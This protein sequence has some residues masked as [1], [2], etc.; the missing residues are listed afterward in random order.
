LA[1]LDSAPRPD[2]A[3]IHAL[4]DGVSRVI[5]MPVFVTVSSHTQAGEEMIAA[6]NPEKYGAKVCYASPLWDSQ[7]LQQSFV[8]RANTSRGQTDKVK[9]GVLLIGHGQPAGWD[10][11]YPTQTEQENL[12]REAIKAKLV[13]D[14]YSPQNIVL[15]WMEFK[16]PLIEDGLHEMA[17]NG[18]EKI[19]VFSTSISAKSIHSDIQVPHAIAAAKLPAN[20]TVLDLGAWGDP[21]NPLLLAAIREKI[22]GCA[23]EATLK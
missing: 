18:V 5:V 14:G 13:A 22:A 4:N 6:V 10:I 11:L 1:F 21:D 3:L 9:T 16:T 7:P 12:F 15:S 20:I 19:I 17:A 8:E 23:L 2:E